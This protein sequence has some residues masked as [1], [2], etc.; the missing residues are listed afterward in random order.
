[1]LGSTTMPGS[2]APSSQRYD[3]VAVYAVFVTVAV[4]VFHWIAEGEFSAILTLS[5]VFQCLAFF[6]FRSA[7]D[8]Q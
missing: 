6:S 8:L 2:K 1:M 4:L 7:C 5:A 3:L